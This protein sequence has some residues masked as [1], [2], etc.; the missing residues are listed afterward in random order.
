MSELSLSTDTG[1]P[2]P[3]TVKFFRPDDEPNPNPNPHCPD[4]D[5]SIR[6]PPYYVNSNP[7]CVVPLPPVRDPFQQPNPRTCPKPIFTNVKCPVLNCPL[8]KVPY[9]GQSNDEQVKT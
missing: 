7:N 2:Q 4:Y 9:C 8:D 1:G 3:L 6:P 5:C